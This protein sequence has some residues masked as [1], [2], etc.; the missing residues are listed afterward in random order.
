VNRPHVHDGYCA[1]DCARVE[2]L[3]ETSQ[4]AAYRIMA[5]KGYGHRHPKDK[6]RWWPFAFHAY[7]AI[8]QVTGI[9]ALAWVAKKCGLTIPGSPP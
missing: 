6:P 2:D 8:I 9:A 1:P 5:R 3:D 7:K 4:T